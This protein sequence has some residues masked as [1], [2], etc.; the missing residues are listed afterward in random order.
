M[1]TAGCFDNHPLRETKLTLFTEVVT[2]AQYPGSCILW[3]EK[4]ALSP[5]LLA[6]K[7]QG[8]PTTSREPDFC[9]KREKSKKR[10]LFCR[11][12]STEG[13]RRGKLDCPGKS[14]PGSS[15]GPLKEEISQALT[16]ELSSLCTEQGD[17]KDGPG[18]GLFHSVLN[19]L[20]A[21]TYSSLDY[22]LLD[23]RDNL[24]LFLSSPRQTNIMCQLYGSKYASC[25]N[26]VLCIR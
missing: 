10:S 11:L 12:G 6:S 5:D 18:D 17:T 23:C 2:K 7:V 1:P 13:K 14:L 24:P 3:E 20:L 21:H 25:R 19:D 15:W 9:R 16:W 26:T 4:G 8:Y 22:K